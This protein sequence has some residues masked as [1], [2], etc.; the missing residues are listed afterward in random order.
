M[1]S[2]EWVAVLLLHPLQIDSA[3]S[4]LRG[5]LMF[6]AISVIG[7]GRTTVF[8]MEGI[9]R[10]GSSRRLLISLAHSPESCGLAVLAVIG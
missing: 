5:L 3:L 9:V 1:S 4:V 2:H 10:S 7:L 6:N 8:S